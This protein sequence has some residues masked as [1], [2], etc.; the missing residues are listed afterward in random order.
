M[1]CYCMKI[2]DNTQFILDAENL[3]ST[4]KTTCVKR[5]LIR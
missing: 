4:S 3:K 2:E 5:Q 1:G